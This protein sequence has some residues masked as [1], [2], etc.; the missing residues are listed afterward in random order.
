MTNP[1][2]FIGF[3]LVRGPVILCLFVSLALAEVWLSFNALLAHFFSLFYVFLEFDR[4]LHR[5]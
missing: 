2:K 4:F 1:T 3:I 5:G